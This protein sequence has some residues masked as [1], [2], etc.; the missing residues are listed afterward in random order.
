VFS[1]CS[2]ISSCIEAAIAK[3]LRIRHKI[4]FCLE[5]FALGILSDEERSTLKIRRMILH[6]VGASGEDFKEQ[7]EFDEIEHEEFFV[8]RLLDVDVSP[9]H[10]F[11]LLS[12]TKQSVERIARGHDDFEEGA[13]RLSRMFSNQHR[14]ASSDG[15]FFIFEM[16][17]S[18]ARVKLY[19]FAKY[20]YS[21]AIERI[22]NAGRSEL[23]QIVQAFI[24]DKKAIQKSCIIRVRN[25]S[26]EIDVAARDR[27]KQA[28]DLSGYFEGFL[29]VSRF[30]TDAELTSQLKEALT[31]ILK[32]CAEDLP[33]G[34]ISRAHSAAREILRNREQI[35]NDAVLEAVL[36]ACGSPDDENVRR[37][38]EKASSRALKSKRLDGVEFRPNRDALGVAS[39]K[40]VETVEGVRLEYPGGLE[41]NGV[42]R[43]QRPGGGI[44]F[45]IDTNK[46][47][48][49]DELVRER[50][51]A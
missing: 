6:V 46:E 3:S 19:S 26:A 33:P 8:A 49:L 51:R 15:A 40:R 22:D 30:R 20:D 13:Q 4:P 32:A 36:V 37:R 28:P 14:G 50:F 44:R 2:V 27:A 7:P 39:R 34:G 29:D 47:L 38:I 10:K 45:T 25:G 9:V 31:D 21:Q 23:R 48:V 24:A 11:N 42:T 43:I 12:D 35:D 1:F 41:G 17:T 16:G 18:D 5:V